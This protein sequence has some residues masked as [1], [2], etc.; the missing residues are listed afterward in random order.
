MSATNFL[1]EKMIGHAFA[2]ESF[3]PGTTFY[4][5]LFTVAP[6]EAGGGTECSGGGYARVSCT[7]SRSSST[8][9]NDAVIEFPVSTAD[10]DPVVATGL[11]DA[12]SGGNLLFYYVFGTPKDYDTGQRPR[13]PAGDFDIT[14]N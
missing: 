7:F 1:E 9:D 12:A 2:G 10:R 14:L 11:F 3:S 5:A 13:F 8:V 6:G 4:A